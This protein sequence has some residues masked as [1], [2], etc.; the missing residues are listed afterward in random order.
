M[1][2]RPPEC[3]ISVLCHKDRQC[4]PEPAVSLLPS[5]VL[6]CE[7][8]CSR[9]HKDKSRTNL[10]VWMMDLK[11]SRG[12]CRVARARR[13]CF[14]PFWCLLKL[15]EPSSPTRVTGRGCAL[16]LDTLRARLPMT[17]TLGLALPTQAT[18][19]AQRGQ[20][21]WL[22]GVTRVPQRYCQDS[23]CKSRTNYF[24]SLCFSFHTCKM[25]RIRDLPASESGKNHLS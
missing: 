11:H 18:R 8:T 15:T 14:C 9:G 25:K 16:L 21:V 6:I 7:R 2:C 19:D 23:L 1:G 22:V 12:L 17:V 24:I 4:D 13:H 5:Q 3:W 20:V 10:K